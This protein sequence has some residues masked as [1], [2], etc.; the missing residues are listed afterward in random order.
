MKLFFI[1]PIKGPVNGVKIIAQH[2]LNAFLNDELKTILIDTSQ[3]EKYKEF[4]SFN[5]KKLFFVF[6]IFKKLKEIS[7][8][9]FVYMNFSTKG[10]SLYRD[11]WILRYL[12]HKKAN[13]T[14][15]I[16]ANG[17][18]EI[19]NIYLKKMINKVK[20]IVINNKQFELLKGYKSVY[21]VKNCL[22]DYYGG[23][24][25]FTYT[26]TE[27]KKLLYMS[28]LSEQKGIDKLMSICKSVENQKNYTI[29]ICGGVLDQYSQEVLNEIL[30]KYK[31]VSFLGPIELLDKKMEIYKE[32]DFLVFL[33][34]ED[35]EVFPLVYIEALMNGLSVI[36]TSQIVLDDI[37]SNE[38][39]L[40]LNDNNY[41]DYINT[42]DTEAKILELKRKN[43]LKFEQ[44][45]QFNAYYQSIKKIIFD[46]S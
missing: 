6:T 35:Y 1:F 38:S 25:N 18:D 8:G 39:G 20:I 40:L 23:E 4:G 33:S 45:F 32:H 2:L 26:Y 27:E 7:K 36:S 5:F 28:N 19:R 30:E 42:Y 13:I 43:R 29:T 16:H 37:I 41:I 24:F 14:I 15:H 46:A 9:D 3:A 12:N 21:C 10:F 11:L 44:S 34:D 31:F 22:P 17:L